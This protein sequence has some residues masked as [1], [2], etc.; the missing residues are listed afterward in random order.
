MKSSYRK[1][2]SNTRR[3]H[4]SP[5]KVKTAVGN[6]PSRG[7]A[8][9]VIELARHL[10]AEHADRLRRQLECDARIEHEARE[11]VT[12]RGKRLEQARHALD[13]VNLS[14]VSVYELARSA[15][16]TRDAQQVGAYMTAVENAAKVICR[17][18]DVIAAL[19]G[20]SGAFGNFEEEFEAL[21]PDHAAMQECGEREVQ[22]A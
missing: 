2:N 14:S 10:D 3:S 20:E 18:C 8:A 15:V 1:S 7:T 6:S 21:T 11:G 9:N 5:A 19:L 22:H 17:K 4:S 12:L 13:D 16:A